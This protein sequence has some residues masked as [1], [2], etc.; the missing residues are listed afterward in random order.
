MPLARVSKNRLDVATRGARALAS[1]LEA[2]GRS[3]EELAR[4][5]RAT[6]ARL[7]G[8]TVL[9]G[10]VLGGTA[11]MANAYGSRLGPAKRVKLVEPKKS[12]ASKAF[13]GRDQNSSPATSISREGVSTR[14]KTGTVIARPR[15]RLE[16]R[17]S[18][19]A[20][21]ARDQNSSPGARRV[22]TPSLRSGPHIFDEGKLKVVRTKVKHAHDSR[23]E[24][25][26]KNDYGNGNTRFGS[27]PTRGRRL[28]K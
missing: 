17:S 16:P 25:Y 19:P 13:S 12:G 14:H 24:I 2:F 9:G 28:P 7:V 27:A 21:V 11:G 1:G 5:K 10:T 23:V 26:G 4:A 15:T 20:F 3:P 8:G 6:R 22:A 18:L